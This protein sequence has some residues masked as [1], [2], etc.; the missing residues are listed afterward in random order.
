METKELIESYGSKG[1]H[2]KGSITHGVLSKRF[3]AVGMFS[4]LLKPDLI[5]PSFHHR[6]CV[7]LA[8]NNKCMNCSKHT[9]LI[10]IPLLAVSHASDCLYHMCF[11]L[12]SL[13]EASL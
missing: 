10:F 6:A 4:T 1:D 7:L 12:Q 9:T 3:V 11:Y 13:I 2:R 5:I 8:S